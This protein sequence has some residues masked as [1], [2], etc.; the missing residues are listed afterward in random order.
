MKVKLILNIKLNKRGTL[1]VILIIFLKFPAN[2]SIKPTFITVVCNSWSIKFTKG[3]LKVQNIVFYRRMLLLKMQL[4]FVC[5]YM[6]TW[7]TL[8]V[9]YAVFQLGLRSRWKWFNTATETPP[10]LTLQL[11][12]SSKEEANQLTSIQTLNLFWCTCDTQLS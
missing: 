5:L 6:K 4:V 10:S 2:I 12:G 3:V 1:L 8:P 9:T 7:I 11:M